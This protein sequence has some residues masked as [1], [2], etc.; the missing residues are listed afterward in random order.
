MINTLSKLLGN[1]P[2]TISNW[3]KE[4][5]NIIKLL[6]K[7]FSK[8]DLEEFL[9]TDKIEKFE[10]MDEYYQFRRSLRKKYL[11]YF[12][13]NLSVSQLDEQ[14][15]IPFIFG[16][17]VF[18]KK[19]SGKFTNFRAAAISFLVSDYSMI[20]KNHYSSIEAV[21]KRTIPFLS[22]LDEI[23]SMYSY[24]SSIV[25]NGMEDLLLIEDEK[26]KKEAMLHHNYFEANNK[27]IDKKL[28]DLDEEPLI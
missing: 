27:I 18:L 16:L 8:E 3:K 28:N 26:M 5:R 23:D 20:E 7:Y 2:K 17:F 22:Y 12:C 25:E 10:K 1:S 14:S 19:Y 9:E 13:E 24:I 21:Q 15:S 4:D 11:Q 6:Y